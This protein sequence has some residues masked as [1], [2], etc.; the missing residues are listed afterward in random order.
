MLTATWEER[1]HSRK[2]PLL[3]TTPRFAAAM[4]PPSQSNAYV[5]LYP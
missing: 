2:H 3:P 4:Y 1:S 5:Y